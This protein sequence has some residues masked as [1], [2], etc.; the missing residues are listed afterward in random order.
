MLNDYDQIICIHPKD[1]STDFLK[2]IGDLFENK[3]YIIEDNEE[4]H[5]NTLSLIRQLQR[6]CLIVFLGHGSS[7]GL[8]SANT[9]LYSKRTFIN[10]DIGNEIFSAHDIFLLCCNSSEYTKQLHSYNSILGFGNILSSKEEVTIEAEYTGILRVLDDD[11]ISKFNM[12]YVHA[13]RSAFTLLFKGKITFKHLKDYIEYFINKEISQILL[14]K[15]KSN[16]IEVSKL[17][18]ELRN[19]MVVRFRC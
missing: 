17:Y 9:H 16:R 1:F 15:E 6:K 13:I 5:Q 8:N 18:F 10:K 11:D 7:S 2:P 19:E 12:S 14:N 3:Y 4:S